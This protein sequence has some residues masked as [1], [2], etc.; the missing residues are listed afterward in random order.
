[1]NAWLPAR[2]SHRRIGIDDTPI[3]NLAFLIGD[4]HG[5]ERYSIPGLA[6]FGRR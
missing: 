1:M 3:D 2:K 4:V 5:H 6:G